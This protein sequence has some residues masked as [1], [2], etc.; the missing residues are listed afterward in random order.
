MNAEPPFDTKPGR[1]RSMTG[2]KRVP[3]RVLLPNIVT[4]LALCAGGAAQTAETGIRPG[5]PHSVVM[6]ASATP[7]ARVEVIWTADRAGPVTLDATALEF[8]TITQVFLDA[9][10]GRRLVGG[11]D[12]SVAWSV[13]RVAF[14]AE[15][16]VTYRFVVPEPDP[17]VARVGALAALWL[18][19]MRRSRTAVRRGC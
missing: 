14:D 13:D 18:L 5:R 15:K 3:M 8:D 12:D 19:G 7:H 1:S 9:P 4:L 2:F 11:D 6:P 16:G 10:S 17:S